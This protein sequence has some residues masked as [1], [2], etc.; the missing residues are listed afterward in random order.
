MVL[1]MPKLAAVM[2]GTL[3]VFPVHAEIFK[4]TGKTGA[5]VYQNFP[6]HLDTIGSVQAAQAPKSESSA[7]AKNA[8]SVGGIPPTRGQP[9]TG[10]TTA[11]VTA[12][13]GEPVDRYEDEQANGRFQIWEYGG[14]RSVR[15]NAKRRVVAVQP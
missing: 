14:N 11:E 2:L 1:P 10:M 3:C 4:C 8:A 5:D 6:C 7:A 9:K 15:F 13:W 12:I